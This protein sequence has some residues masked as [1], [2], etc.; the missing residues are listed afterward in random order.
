VLGPRRWV[1][2]L[3]IVSV[4]AVTSCP[5]KGRPA[6]VWVGPDETSGGGWAGPPS[7]AGRVWLDAHAAGALLA[8]GNAGR[9]SAGAQRQ[10]GGGCPQV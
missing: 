7:R 6:E 8:S 2:R 1:W 5:T 3:W 4:V 10:T 9:G